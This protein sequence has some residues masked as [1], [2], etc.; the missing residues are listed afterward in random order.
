MYAAASVS[1]R[2]AAEEEGP[3][4]PRRKA[5][6]GG[7]KVKDDKIETKQEKQLRSSRDPRQGL[8]LAAIICASNPRARLERLRLIISS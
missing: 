5:V 4:R 3:A 2:T 8:L 7:S 1:S 6:D